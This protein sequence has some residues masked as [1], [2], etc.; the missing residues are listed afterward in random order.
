MRKDDVHWK[1]VNSS[2]AGSE[3]KILRAFDVTPEEEQHLDADYTLSVDKESYTTDQC[4]L[5]VG[6]LDPKASSLPRFSFRWDEKPKQLDVDIH[7]VDETVRSWFE[8]GE[9]G[10][11]GHRP[12]EVNKDRRLFEIDI[13]I[14]AKHVFKGRIKFN[15]N[16]LDCV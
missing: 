11:S 10:Y 13:W 12:Q 1:G 14:P 15:L 7:D 2:R 9:N 8:H 6:R 4:W 16:T 5:V 3:G